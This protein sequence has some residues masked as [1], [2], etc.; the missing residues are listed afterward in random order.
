MLTAASDSYLVGAVL[1]VTIEMPFPVYDGFIDK[2][3]ESSPEYAILK[4]GLIVRRPKEDHFERI[5]EIRCDTE[6]ADTLS[7]LASKVYPDAVEY[8]ARAI[9]AAMKSD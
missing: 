3:D 8:I 2:C 5:M 7:A 6:E 9:M 1:Q 4:N